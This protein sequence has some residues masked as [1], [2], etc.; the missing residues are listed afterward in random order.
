MKKS[1]YFELSSYH[2]SEHDNKLHGI[3]W[4]AFHTLEDAKKQGQKIKDF[5]KIKYP[6]ME[7][8]IHNYKT[9]EWFIIE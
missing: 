1:L 6:D 9:G 2:I 8:R 5:N 4:G 7:V 3:D